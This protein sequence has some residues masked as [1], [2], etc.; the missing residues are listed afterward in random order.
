MSGGERADVPGPG[1]PARRHGPGPGRAVSRPRATPSQA[2]DDALGVALS[3]IMWEGPE[4]ELTLTHN[5]QPA[6]LAHSAAV[7][8][9]V[10]GPVGRDRRRR[11]TQPRRVQRPRRRRHAEPPPSRPRLVRRRGELMLA[12]GQAAARRDGRR[13]R[14]RD[15]AGGPGLQRGVGVRRRRGGRQPQRARPDRHLRRSRRPWRARATAAR[16][17]APSGSIPLKVSG[18]FHSPLMAPAVDGLHDALTRRRRSRTRRFRSSPTR[19]ARR[20]A[21]APTPSACWSISSPR[22]SGGS[23]ACR[24]AAALAP[25]ATLPRDRPG[26][27]AGR[28]AQADRA[29]RR[30]RHARDR[31]RGGE[32]P[33]MKR[34]A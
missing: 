1:R 8:A 26:Q 14:P 24:R 29:R 27:R 34:T 7:W 25:G 19:A 4:D 20:C 13:A 10:E 15:G 28:A 30:R 17:A 3:R 12:A 5:A 16:R 9:V 23:P 31:R 33:R 18:A 22:R 32:V 21:P 2:I 11:R 6:I